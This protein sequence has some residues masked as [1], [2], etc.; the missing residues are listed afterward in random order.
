MTQ[1]AN[2]PAYLQIEDSL[3]L[4]A[5]KFRVHRM[6][7]GA[8]LFVTTAIGATWAATG[9]VYLVSRDGHGAGSAGYVSAAIWG[10]VMIAAAV[11][12]IF[13]PLLLRPRAIEIARLI[14]SRLDGMHN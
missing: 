10:A 4:V 8:V 1:L 5:Q 3:D 2:H 12:W 9:A 6:V 7:R 11:L 13:R 14:E